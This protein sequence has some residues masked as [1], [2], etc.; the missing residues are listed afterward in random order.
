[1]F[2]FYWHEHIYRRQV[3]RGHSFVSLKKADPGGRAVYGLGVRLF[4]CWDWGFE[5]RRGYRCLSLKMLWV[6]RLSSLRRVFHPPGA[7]LPIVVC[8]SVFLKARQWGCPGPLGLLR[9]KKEIFGVNRWELILKLTW[10]YFATISAFVLCDLGHTVK[11]NC[12]I[13]GSQK[14]DALDFH[15]SNKFLFFR[16]SCTL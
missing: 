13:I 10:I 7:V 11:T 9:H 12:T 5:S 8:L 6:V 2:R 4:A 1:M 16:G 15:G 14:V 3:Y